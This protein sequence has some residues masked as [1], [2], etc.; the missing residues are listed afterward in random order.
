MTFSPSNSNAPYLPT[1]T[2][3]PEN[4]EEFRV[5]FLE[6]Y[7][8]ISSN[9]NVRQIG[10]FDLV[11]SLTGQQWFTSGNPQIKR[12][13]FRVVVAFGAFAAG[14]NVAIP[15]GISNIATFTHI[16]GA[17]ITTTAGVGGFI[18]VPLPFVSITASNNCIEVKA[19]ATNIYLSLGAGGFSLSSGSIIL[20]YLKN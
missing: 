16:Y 12:Q 18:Q 14:S 8:D 1:S 19:D 6:L 20:E 9:T 4:F 13:T 7:R 5:K 17:G 15:H 2:F 10:V 11:E 3:F